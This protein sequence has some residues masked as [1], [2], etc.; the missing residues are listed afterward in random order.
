MFNVFYKIDDDDCEFT[1]YLDGKKIDDKTVDDRRQDHLDNLC[2][3][4]QVDELAD[5]NN[6]IID[7]VE[8]KEIETVFGVNLI[9]STPLPVRHFF[10]EIINK[11]FL[12]YEKLEVKPYQ[13]LFSYEKNGKLDE[14]EIVDDY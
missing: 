5:T 6:A 3:L 14:I 4:L 11:K 1:Y 10:Y 9:I 7:F 8:Q 12:Y 2:K 13:C